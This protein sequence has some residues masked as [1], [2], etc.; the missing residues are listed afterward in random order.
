LSKL[1]GRVARHF[2][3]GEASIVGHIIVSRMADGRIE[4]QPAK[5]I[6]WSLPYLYLPSL[7]AIVAEDPTTRFAVVSVQ[8]TGWSGNPAGWYIRRPGRDHRREP[9]GDLTR[10]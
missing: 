10:D 5:L 6:V 9:E 1:S 3:P 8:P 7:K 2:A 4:I